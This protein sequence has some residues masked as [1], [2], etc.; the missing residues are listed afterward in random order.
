MVVP[1]AQMIKIA[2]V[3]C[4]PIVALKDEDFKTVTAWRIEAWRIVACTTAA[5][6]SAGLSSVASG[7]GLLPPVAYFDFRSA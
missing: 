3:R 1:I 7:A 2:C 5:G 4:R 6:A